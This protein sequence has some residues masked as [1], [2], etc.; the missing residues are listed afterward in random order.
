MKLSLVVPETRSVRRVAELAGRAE[1]LGVHGMFLGTAFGFDPIVALTLA[2]SA[3]TRLQLGT[4]IVPTWTR[5]P[6][7]MAQDAATGSYDTLGAVSTDFRRFE[8][9]AFD[10][11]GYFSQS[12]S[13]TSASTA[14]SGLR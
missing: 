9:I 11:Y 2:G 12:I 7:V 1:A 4:S 8:I 5:H 3:T 10:Q 6:L 14:L 13:L